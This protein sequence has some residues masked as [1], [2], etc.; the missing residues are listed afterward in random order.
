MAKKINSDEQPNTKQWRRFS[1]VRVN[2]GAFKRHARKLET[3]TVKHAHRFLIRRWTNI[4]NVGRLT[5]SWLVL[6]GLLI[7]LASMQILWYRDGY[8]TTAPGPGGTYA[9]GSVGQLETTNPLF[10]TTSP[11]VAASKLLFSGLLTHDKTNALTPDIADSWSVSEDGKTY[12]VVLRKDVKWHDG[13]KLTADDVMFTVKL[14]QNEQTKAVQYASWVGVRA[15]KVDDYHVRFV[16]PS[17]YAPFAQSLMFGIL[18]QHILKDVAPASLRENAFGRNPVGTGPFVFRRLQVIDPNKNRLVLHM[19]SNPSYHRGAPLLNRFQIHTYENSEALK[20]AYVTSEVAAA[21]GLSVNQLKDIT[22]K[23]KDSRASEALL[24]DAVFAIMNN[25]SPLLKEASLRQALVKATNKGALLRA[26]NNRGVALNGP[27]PENIIPG[28]TA[29]QGQFDAKAAAGLLDASGWVRKAN[30]ERANGETPLVLSLVAPEEGD[31]KVIVEEL[32]RQWRE[33]GIQTKIQL[34]KPKDIA[35]G[36]LQ[37]RNYDVLVYELVV[38]ADPDVYFYWHSSQ[39]NPR[40]LNFANYRSGVSDDI[41]SSA[42][43]QLSTLLL[44]AKHRSFAEQWV[45]DA[46]AIALYQPKFSY[47]VDKTIFSFD[48]KQP[49]AEAALRYRDVHRWSV[50][51]QTVMRTP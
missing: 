36:Y 24:N 6:T 12:D 25:D 37:P 50:Q 17:V 18:P 15:E 11:E 2:K 41:L 34:I 23:Y 10:A 9:E 39:A 46:P 4:R 16:L 31:Y 26:L 14:M 32:A 42:R 7:A 40:G 1:N 35:T 30:G 27:L 28:Q 22:E 48:D 33:L 38:G 43:T 13:Q 47:I 8:T 49:V 21:D 51:P 3:A 29:R 19:E 20:R 5:I 45:K 44:Q